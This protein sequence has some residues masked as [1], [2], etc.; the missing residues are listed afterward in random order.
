MSRLRARYQPNGIPPNLFFGVRIAQRATR[1]RP[2]RVSRRRAANALIWRSSVGSSSWT[3]VRPSST[4]VMAALEWAVSWLGTRLAIG[5]ATR[6]PDH[7]ATPVLI[8]PPRSAAAWVTRFGPGT[9]SEPLSHAVIMSMVLHRS[10]RQ[11]FAPVR[12]SRRRLRLCHVLRREAV[13]WSWK[14]KCWRCVK[15][16]LLHGKPHVA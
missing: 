1:A 5:Y 14:G 4:S 11:A 6:F 10:S 3:R 15:D 9:S 12:P 2:P 8:T 7:L 13:E 16:D